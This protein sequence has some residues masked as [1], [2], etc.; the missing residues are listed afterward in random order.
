MIRRDNWRNV[1][2][3]IENNVE[4]KQREPQPHT[5]NTRMTA[6]A[7]VTIPTTR[8]TPTTPTAPTNTSS[9]TGSNTSSSASEHHIAV[10]RR[11]RYWTLGTLSA[12]TR[13]VWFV[14]HG[15]G[16]LAEYFIR[17]F[18]ALDDGTRFIV[19]P[20][21][22]SR[23]YLK[24]FTGR[25]GAT[26]MTRED[27]QSE[28]ADYVEY[29]DALY[30][31]IYESAH[32][33]ASMRSADDLLGSMHSPPPIQTTVL[34]FSQGVASACRWLHLGKYGTRGLDLHNK[35]NN[36]PLHAAAAITPPPVN[37][38]YCWAGGLPMDIDFAEFKPL[39][40]RVVPVFAVG[41]DDEFITESVIAAQRAAF[42]TVGLPF[43]ME[44]FNGGH[45]IDKPL[46]VRLAEE[47][48]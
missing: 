19:A 15:Y 9:S 33:Q 43:R 14:L 13:E 16:Q 27:R 17:N 10:T 5:H 29:L 30:E 1:G 8:T 11:A 37:R 24:E 7:P 47:L 23:F 46:L 20:E 41:T 32:T 25:I 31:S 45:H 48:P 2:T 6:A 35:Q 38:L 40:E 36:S 22:L 39:F 18:T 26:W 28:I 12:A 21:A 4:H 44:T 34:A 3:V 42:E